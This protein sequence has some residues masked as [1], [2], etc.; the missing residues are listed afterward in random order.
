LTASKPLVAPTGMTRK[1]SDANELDE[2]AA[3]R[4]SEDGPTP[5]GLARGHRRTGVGRRVQDPT[6]Q[7]SV[8]P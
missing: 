6:S 8:Q 7:A 3:T 2:T 1:C 4:F 5:S